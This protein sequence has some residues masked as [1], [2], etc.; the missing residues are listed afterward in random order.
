[1]TAALEVE[2]VQFG[3]VTIA[4]DAS[5]LRPRPWTLAQAEWAA[6]LVGY[7]RLLELGAGAGQIGLAAAALSR[8]RLVQVDRDPSACAWAAANAARNGLSARVEQRCGA[9]ADALAPGETFDVA[10]VDP[11]YVPTAEVS[12]FPEDPLAAIDGGSDG[13][14]SIRQ[15]VAGVAAHLAPDASVLL[16]VRGEAQVDAV[17]GWLAEEGSPA[18][19]VVERRIYGQDRALARLIPETSGLGG[20]RS[21]QQ[22]QAAV[23]DVEVSP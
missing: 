10:I 20:T 3:P 17:E 7:G 13:L 15:F 21:S 9:V 14:A 2:V 16:Q 19:A 18:L 5:V 4:F 23:C 1:M 8:R 22:R 6:H 11:P 12:R